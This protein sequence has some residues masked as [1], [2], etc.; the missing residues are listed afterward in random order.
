MIL[1]DE[2]RDRLIRA[3]PERGTVIKQKLYIRC[4]NK[5]VGVLTDRTIS[6]DGEILWY[7]ISTLRRRWLEI[8]NEPES[9][10]RDV[11]AE[12]GRTSILDKSDQEIVLG[13]CEWKEVCN[14]IA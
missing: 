9:R 4:E 14:A 2:L 10:E 7:M 5:V 8:R 13:F 6:H 1:S 3:D 11:L 12:F